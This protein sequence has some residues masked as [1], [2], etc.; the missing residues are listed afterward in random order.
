MMK[1][2][3]LTW[4]AAF[5]SLFQYTR[6]RKLLVYLL[7][8][9]FGM[10]IP[11]LLTVLFF[12]GKIHWMAFVGINLVARLVFAPLDDYTSDE[13]AY[14]KLS[15]FPLNLPEMLYVRQVTKLVQISEW[16]FAA[17]MAYVYIVSFGLGWGLGLTALTLVAIGLGEELAFYLMYLVKNRKGYVAAYLAACLALGVLVVL[18]PAVGV[19]WLWA[20]VAAVLL[21]CCLVALVVLHR[22]FEKLH[23]L[24]ALRNGGAEGK[25]PLSTRLMVAASGGSVLKRLVCLE[26]ITMLKWKV[27]NLISALGY[28]VVFAV[29]DKSQS[30][31]YAMVQYFIVDYCFL[32]GFNFFGNINDREGLFLF[33]TVD[34]KTRIRSKILALGSVLVVLSTLLTVALAV[35]YGVDGKTL[36][37]TLVANLFCISVM[38]LA[39]GVVSITHFH[40]DDS[41]KK[42]TAGNLVIM[43]SILIVNSVLAALLL[44]GGVLSAVSLL[45]MG[46]MTLACLYFALVDM[47]MLEKLFQKHQG[48]MMEALRG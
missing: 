45:F 31:M 8:N 1:L 2:K 7:A 5:C 4:F 10:V 33:S 21:V 16:L 26:W 18:L 19:A 44:A 43:L 11:A 35:I 47:S 9:T 41:K 27:W 40:L 3:K 24:P 29:M 37:L 34:A 30:M 6:E 25:M 46:I 48:R 32:V 14:S 15:T 13:Y 38:L 39:S 23:K 17:A 28:V 42:Y 20:A 36:V 22:N 12:Q